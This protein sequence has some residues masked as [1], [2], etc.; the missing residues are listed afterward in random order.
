[1]SLKE[2]AKIYCFITFI[3][4]GIFA[5]GIDFETSTERVYYVIRTIV[6]VIGQLPLLY[7]CTW[8]TRNIRRFVVYGFAYVLFMLVMWQ[9]DARL[10]DIANIIATAILSATSW[11]LFLP[12]CRRVE[13]EGYGYHG[14]S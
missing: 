11:C 3:L 6:C 1:M 2:Y 4:I 12:M 8:S 9:V 5:V 7:I 10:S 13:D 14:E